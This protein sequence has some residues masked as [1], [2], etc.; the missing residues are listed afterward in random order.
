MTNEGAVREAHG[1]ALFAAKQC[2]YIERLL[3]LLIEGLR[4][5]PDID[6]HKVIRCLTDVMYVSGSNAGRL[7]RAA[8]LCEE[9]L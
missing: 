6:R 3:G 1:A 4:L 2:R 5:A 8:M 7:E 9:E